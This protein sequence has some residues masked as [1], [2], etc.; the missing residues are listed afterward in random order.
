[1]QIVRRLALTDA[2][3]LELSPLLSMLFSI[4]NGGRLLVANGG[5]EFP[6]TEPPRV[7]F[8]I[9]TQWYR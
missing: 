1:M 5:M 9:S 3:R 2:A 4:R 7:K 8:N 6:G